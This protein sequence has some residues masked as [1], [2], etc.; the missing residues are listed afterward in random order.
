MARKAIDDV[1]LPPDGILMWDRPKQRVGKKAWK[2]EYGFD[3]GPDGGY[4]P[5]MS[6]DDANRWKA[7]LVGTRTGFPQVE[8]RKQAGPS[9]MLIIVNLGAGYSYK[10][11][12]PSYDLEEAGKPWTSKD[13]LPMSLVD[14]IGLQEVSAGTQVHISM[15]GPAMMDFEDL[16]HMHRA[17]EEA[18]A[19]LA[20]LESAPGERSLQHIDFDEGIDV[21]AASEALADIPGVRVHLVLE[22]ER[23]VVVSLVDSSLETI[24]SMPGVV[25]IR[26]RETITKDSNRAL[27]VAYGFDEDEDEDEA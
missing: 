23:F 5:N 6:Q 8:I 18:K 27:N 17:V 16:A 3:G 22:K 14:R 4:Q 13:L 9:L 10:S 21:K 19:V 11:N 15:N 7:K 1:Q 25:R 26:D 2:D 12:T 24:R 20:S